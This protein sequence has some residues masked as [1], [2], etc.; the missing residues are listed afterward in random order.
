M[1]AEI[2]PNGESSSAL[3]GE[4]AAARARYS[5]TAMLLGPNTFQRIQSAR[6]L[7]VGAGG[8][9]CELLKNLVLAGFGNIEIIDLDTIDLSNLNRQFLFQKQHIK[10]PKALVARA[11]ALQ[12]NPHVSITAHH[13]N[14]KEPRFGPSYFRQ[15]DAVLN[16]LDNIDARRWVNRICV[17]TGVPLVESGTT[18]FRGQVQPINPGTTECYDCQEKETP[19]TFPVCTIRSTPSTPIHCIV[20]AKSWLFVQLFGADDETEDAELDKALV[21]GENKDEIEALRAEAAEMRAIRSDLLQAVSSSSTAATKEEEPIPSESVNKAVRQVFDKVFRKDIERLLRMESMW[22]N[23]EKPT[24]LDF[25]ALKTLVEDQT[26]TVVAGDA[27]G[28]NAAVDGATAGR[29]RDQQQLSWKDTLELFERSTA[30]LALRASRSSEPLSWD[31][32]DPPALDFVT[33]ASNLR[34]HIYSIQPRKTRFE[35]KQMAGNIIPAIASTNAII[36]GMLVLQAIHVLQA[37]WSQARCVNLSRLGGRV[38]TI[39]PPQKPNPACGVCADAYVELG[40]DPQ[41]ATLRQVLS[42]VVRAPRAAGGLAYGSGGDF[43]EDEEVELAAYEGDRILWD[44]DFEDNADSKLIDLG[45]EPGKTLVVRDEDAKW[46]TL[47][48]LIGDI[49]LPAECADRA[50]KSWVLRGKLPTI[51]RKPQPAKKPEDDDDDAEGDDDDVV[52]ITVN[53]EP[54]AGKKRPAEALDED[55]EATTGDAAGG[56]GDKAR[57]RQRTEQEAGGESSSSPSKR[58]RKSAGAAVVGSSA[59]DAIELD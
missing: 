14:I 38:C 40:I 12:F 28:Q 30:A 34:S 4:A 26:T 2:A 50:N 49:P 31:K 6:I 18:G 46:T 16:A 45:L 10:Q 36:A 47:N 11:T 13:A 53:T 22:T 8:I 41:T 55:K 15:F 56:E 23:R 59:T 21:E 17:A 24:P 48:L 35:V 44:A 52:A 19:K 54:V 37:D 33:A 27:S 57:K 42:D 9:G 29:L 43:D 32:D 25:D 3:A 58:P 7:V 5:Y 51:G 20:W 39:Y 1:S